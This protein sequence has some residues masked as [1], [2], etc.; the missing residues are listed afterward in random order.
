[1]TQKLWSEVD[2]YIEDALMHSDTALDWVLQSI[3]E[4]GLPAISVSPPQG[5][6]LHLLARIQC[7]RRILEIGTLGGYSTIWLGQALP[8]DG[9][10]ITLEI[11]AKC[12]EI[13]GAN[14]ERAGLSKIVELRLGP[15]V[16]TLS[17]LVDDGS[18]PFDLIF[19]DADKSGYPDYL[20]WSLKLSRRGT[21]IVAD[22]VVRNGAVVDAT[23]DDANVIGV[24]RFNEL[25]SAEPR[26]SSTTIQ[27][28]GNKGYDGFSFILVVAD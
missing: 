19:L 9:K 26:I 10:L 28:V 24:R 11:D 7:A 8:K 12:A 6:F 21:V 25:L 17:K 27:T 3:A 22:N 14:I 23:T 20:K 15:G 13:A 16:D 18:A 1:M 5:K 4:A 2:Q